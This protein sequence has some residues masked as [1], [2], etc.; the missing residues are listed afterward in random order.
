MR[1]SLAT[2]VI[3]AACVV[4]VALPGAGAHETGVHDDPNTMT[5]CEDH[6]DIK[7]FDVV[8]PITVALH[9]R[10]IFG[11]N[12]E[13]FAWIY[14][15]L[16][17][18]A[19][20]VWILI[21]LWRILPRRAIRLKAQEKVAEVS[22]GHPATYVLSLENRRSRRP[23]D[24]EVS[25]TKPPKGW[26]ASMQVEKT[27]PSGFIELMGE[28]DAMRIPLSARKVG[29]NRAQLRV[30]VR[31]PQ[32]AESDE[33]SEL[34]VSAIPYIRDEPRVRRGK[35][36]RLVTL[37]KTREAKAAITRVSHDPAGFRVHD[38][39][40][41]TVV[42]SN[43]GDDETEPVAIT[44]EINGEEAGREVVVIPAGGEACIEF[45]WIADEPETRVRVTVE[46]DE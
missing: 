30:T 36:T 14:F 37:L 17:G 39:V 44:L 22:A 13:L 33:W 20:T 45:P 11:D 10:G 9:I 46:A 8:C 18:T 4:L 25:I 29:G 15:G 26:S 31:S 34:D 1:A 38:D 23:L 40:T 28:D 16:A 19:I 6:N 41:T 27:L 24:V 7:A 21:L 35:E 3:L 42:V 12:S 2:I 32:G 43:E 5:T